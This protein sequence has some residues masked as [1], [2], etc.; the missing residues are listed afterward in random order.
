[1][2]AQPTTQSK[3][4]S[5]EKK[6]FGKNIQ[7]NVNAEN[8]RGNMPL[9][10][11]K[12][13]WKKAFVISICI[14][15]TILPKSVFALIRPYPA[16]LFNFFGG[17]GIGS[18]AQGDTNGFL[19]YIATDLASLGAMISGIIALRTLCN[20]DFNPYV[21]AGYDPGINVWSASIGN[22]L[23]I[24]TDH[25][26]KYT[27]VGKFSTRVRIFDAYVAGSTLL[28]IASGVP[29]LIMRFHAAMRPFSHEKSL[30]RPNFRIPRLKLPKVPIFPDLSLKMQ[31]GQFYIFSGVYIFP[32]EKRIY[33][34]G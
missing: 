27:G 13:C 9:V 16:S 31:R 3:K 26:N 2:L 21:E 6:F 1:M 23:Q 5:L 34:Y 22:L 30:D 33:K 25:M 8:N 18:L 32:K 15:C 17:F 11:K 20:D 12:H 29:F 4:N 28:V 10:A 14:V 19:K 7:P 24:D